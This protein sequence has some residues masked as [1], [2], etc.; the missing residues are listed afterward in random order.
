MQTLKHDP[1][2]LIPSIAWQ[3]R[4]MFQVLL[5]QRER[6]SSFEIRERLN[7]NDF[8]LSK[9]IEY[10]KGSSV[11]RIVDLLEH[12]ASLDQ[13][14]KSGKVDKKFGFELFMIEATR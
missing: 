6:L 4:L 1:V 2:A 8:V 5:L 10:A 12:L 13:Q 7:E 3:L 9:A 14:I 11:E